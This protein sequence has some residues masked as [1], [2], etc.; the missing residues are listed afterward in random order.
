MTAESVADLKL[1]TNV[2]LAAVASEPDAETP[3]RDPLLDTKAN[4]NVIPHRPVTRSIF[5]MGETLRRERDRTAILEVSPCD[6]AAVMA[7]YR[8]LE[9]GTAPQR[10]V[11]GGGI[12]CD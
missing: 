5:E 11:T 9:S 6:R 10:P 7:A 8:W 4:P 2:A 1:G 3:L 12:F